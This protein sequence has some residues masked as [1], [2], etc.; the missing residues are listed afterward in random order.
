LMPGNEWQMYTP[1]LCS[2]FSVGCSTSTF[3]GKIYLVSENQHH[4]F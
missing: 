3:L 4:T 2:L 1:D